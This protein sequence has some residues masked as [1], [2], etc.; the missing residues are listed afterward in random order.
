MLWTSAYPPEAALAACARIA[1]LGTALVCAEYLTY[2]AML[3]DDA[4]MTWEVSRLRKA[5]LT[6][7]PIAA[8]LDPVLSTRGVRG[9]LF[10]RLLLAL[11]ILFFPTSAALLLASGLGT[12]LF[13][14]RTPFGHDGADQL[15]MILFLSLGLGSLVGSAIGVQI[16]LAFV[17]AQ[18]VLAY[19]SA[20]TAKL[21]AAGWRDGSY[22]AGISGMRMYGHARCARLFAEKPRI[23]WIAA[24]TTIVWEVGF[25]LVPFLPPT[26]AVP[27][28]A[29]GLLFHAGNAVVMG[30]NTFVFAFVATYP[31]LLC[32]IFRR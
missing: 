18:A 32:W 20:G 2:R 3:D 23:A 7:G 26:L 9:L 10:V 1:A 4:L 19:F 12:M 8:L 25:I 11:G 24:W 31:A 28:V 29:L 13:V 27:Y 14:Q 17:A 21:S 30:L 16:A 22:L 6:F 5:W 15:L